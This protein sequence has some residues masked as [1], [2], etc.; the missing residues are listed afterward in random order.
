MGALKTLLE[1]GGGGG[2]SV[3]VDAMAVYH[4]NRDS[5]SNGGCCCAWTVPTGVTWF[6]VEMWGGGGGGAG[7]CCCFFGTP[8]GSG[9]YSRK[10][11]QHPTPGTTLAGRVYRI[12]A[13]GS[14]GCSTQPAGGCAGNPSYVYGESEGSNIVCA[15]PG[16]KG[17]SHCWGPIG[18]SYMGCRSEMC[19]SWT[20]GFGMCGVGGAYKGTSYCSGTA[21][22]WAP[23]AP[24][25]G[26]MMRPGKDACSGYC[27]GCGTG[28]W[29]HFPGGGGWT[30]SSHT[31]GHVGCG[32]AGAGGLVLLQWQVSA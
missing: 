23:S 26:G 19:G 18:S 2:G 32:A 21:W 4:T 25:M 10:I 24:F 7:S 22:S 30:T 13:G 29:P 15:S 1:Y 5:A 20:G 9:S 11:I 16:T 31:S 17:C 28:G 12:C 8:G 27:C 14:T 6:S 3:S